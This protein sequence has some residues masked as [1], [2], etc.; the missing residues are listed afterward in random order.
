MILVVNRLTFQYQLNSRFEREF[1]KRIVSEQ[2]F[3]RK[4]NDLYNIFFR[5]NE[6][7]K[8]RSLSTVTVKQFLQQFQAVLSLSLLIQH[9]VK[10]MVHYCQESRDLF[11]TELVLFAEFI[12]DIVVVL[13]KQ[14]CFL[15]WFAIFGIGFEIKYL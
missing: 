2:S 11:V 9:I 10:Y 15:N 3:H 4:L 7:L 6:Y 14:I 8:R 13:K 5:K 12:V 1:I